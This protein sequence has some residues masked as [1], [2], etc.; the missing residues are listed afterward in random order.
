MVVRY[1]D[2]KLR[3]ASVMTDVFCFM[4]DVPSIE[5]TI[6]EKRIEKVSNAGFAAKEVY[7]LKSTS[8][9]LSR[10]DHM[11][12][13]EQLEKMKTI[14]ADFNHFCGYAYQD[15]QEKGET[16]FFSYSAE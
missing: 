13:T 16:G 8:T 3:M 2:L 1:E 11:Y 14:L 9:S 4:L 10:N 5:G 12:T 15:G 7:K 6:V